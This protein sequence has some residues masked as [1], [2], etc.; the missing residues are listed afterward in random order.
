MIQGG[1]LAGDPPT[2]RDMEKL[3][4]REWDQDARGR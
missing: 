3:L 1:S 2:A 4:E